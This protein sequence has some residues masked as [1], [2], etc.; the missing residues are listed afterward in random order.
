MRGRFRQCGTKRTI[1]EKS[2]GRAG[3]AAR[4]ADRASRWTTTRIVSRLAVIAGRGKIQPMSGADVLAKLVPSVIAACAFAWLVAS[5]EELSDDQVRQMIIRDSIAAYPGVCACPYN[6]MQNGD[7]VGAAEWR[8]CGG[9]SAYSKPG[10]FSPRC[11]PKDVSDDEVSRWRQQHRE[12]A[13]DR[14]GSGEER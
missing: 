11:Y 8:R 9:R 5:A 4:N 13:P 10:G 2:Q 1:S 14:R 3:T 12:Q 6:V 7:A